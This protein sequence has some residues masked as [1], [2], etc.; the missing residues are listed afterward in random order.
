[1]NQHTSVLQTGRERRQA[2]GFSVGTYLRSLD[3]I[4]LGATLALAVLRLVHAVL[5]HPC[6]SEYLQPLLLRA[7]TG[8]RSGAGIRL[9]DH[10]ERG[11]L[12]AHRA[13]EDL[14]LRSHPGTARRHPGLRSR[15]RDG[16]GQPLA[17]VALL[18]AADVGVGQAPTHP[19]LGSRAGRGGGT[20]RPPPLRDPVSSCIRSS[21][22]PSCSYSPTSGPPWCSWSS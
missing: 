18:E 2:L 19:V 14:Y 20:P 13:L 15:E 8:D 10:P 3:W 5:G 6:R 21:L 9:H 1:M 11:E 22:A 16:R 7:L 12:S 17:R 4:L